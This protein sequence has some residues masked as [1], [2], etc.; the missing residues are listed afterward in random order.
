[1]FYI[2][3]LFFMYFNQVFKYNSCQYSLEY[4]YEKLSRSAIHFSISAFSPRSSNNAPVSFVIAVKEPGTCIRL[5]NCYNCIMFLK[6][7][8][9][10]EI[11][12]SY[13]IIS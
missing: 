13:T 1:M 5:Q 10:P 8:N 9:S 12:L 11:K 6:Y 2:F 4:I 3:I 7:S